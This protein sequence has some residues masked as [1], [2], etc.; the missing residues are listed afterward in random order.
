MVDFEKHVVF[1][2]VIGHSGSCPRTRLDDVIVDGSLVYLVVP[3]ITDEMG[4]TDDW[5]PRT[6]LVGMERDL[7]PAPP[8]QLTGQVGSGAR[9]EIATDLRVP[10]S[11]PGGRGR[12]SAEDRRRSREP[13]PMPYMDRNRVPDARH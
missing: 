9:V 13:T 7:L 2:L 5:V 8:F 1:S 12:G 6:Y 11:R 3:T 4:C 10:G